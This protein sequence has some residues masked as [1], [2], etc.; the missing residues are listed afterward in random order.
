MTV[1]GAVLIPVAIFYFICKPFYLLP[2]L[3]I[4]SLLEVGS[5]FNGAI[6][7]F[8]FGLPPFYMVAVL[9]ALRLVMLL[10]RKRKILPSLND[11]M[12]GA[13]V[14]LVAFW[15]W[16]FL[17]AF[18]MPQIFAGMP[19]YSPREGLNI[20]FNDLAALRWTMS[21]LAQ[22]FYLTL[23]VA[24]VLYALHVV[25]TEKQS[26]QLA[27]AFYW[28][29]FIA[30]GAGLLQRVAPSSF[31]Y[32]VFNNNPSYYQGFDQEIDGF[33]RISST[34][35]EPSF[36]GSYLSAVA[37]GL[38]ASYLGGKRSFRKL[39]VLLPVI[40]V[41]VDTTATTGYIAFAA[42]FFLLLIYFNPMSKKTKSE[43]SAFKGWIGILAA[44]S[45]GA[46][47]L[48]LNPALFDAV[49]AVTVEKMGGWSFFHRLAADIYALTLV[50][51]TYGMG[52]GLGSNRPSSLLMALLSTVGLVGTGLFGMMLYKIAQLYPGR[53]ASSHIHVAC[54]ALLGLLIADAIGVPDPNRP[55]LWGMFV[56]VLAELSVCAKGRASALQ[57]TVRAEP[58]VRAPLGGTVGP[59]PA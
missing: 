52:V 38:L 9:I 59:L 12:R 3:V 46:A 56:M 17:S 42:S 16:S 20:E 21:N 55:A 35:A 24:A 34:F 4:T 50:K 13:A 39:L 1:L 14:L 45:I 44:L 26:G 10:K 53:R 32:E 49:S 43:S 51:N 57:Q 40:A 54:W 37:V 15:A 5:V 33:R 36:A 2:L 19:V 58:K 28:A 23:D 8:E 48:F 22:A 31:P 27:T 7:N 41:L 29:I 25:K 30:V 47:A 11:P 6:G 18:L